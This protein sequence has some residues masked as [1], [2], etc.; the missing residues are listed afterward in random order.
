MMTDSIRLQ[1]PMAL[2]MMLTLGA[3]NGG[4]DS[5]EPPLAANGAASAVSGAGQ[6]ASAVGTALCTTAPSTVPTLGGL[7]HGAASATAGPAQTLTL[8]ETRIELQASALGVA[9]QW[10]QVSGPA[11]AVLQHANLPRTLVAADTPGDYVFKLTSTDCLGTVATSETRLK[12][13]PNPVVIT[14][15]STGLDH[16]LSLNRPVFKKGNTLLPLSQYSCGVGGSIRAELVKNWGYT[17]QFGSGIPVE[18]QLALVKA[19]PGQYP[20]EYNVGNVY[21]YFHNYRFGSDPLAP[22]LPDST[23][24]RDKNGNF[25]GGEVRQVSSAAPDASFFAVGAFIG[26]R[27]AAIE[28]A[29]GSKISLMVNGN[30][31]GLSGMPSDQDPVSMAHFAA[32]PFASDRFAYA[33]SQKARQEHFIKEGIFSR[34]KKGRPVYSLYGEAYGTERGRWWGWREYVST[35]E[36]WFTKDGTPLVSDYSAPEFYYTDFNSGWTGYH[37]GSMVP[38]DA[39]NNALKNVSGTLTVLKQK[40]F[41]PWISMGWDGHATSD[42][43]MFMGAMKAYYTAGALGASSGDYACKNNSPIYQDGPVGRNLP[44]QIKGFHALSHV[45]GLFTFLEDFVRN[46]DLLPSNDI[47]SFSEAGETPTP[48]MEFYAEN[49]IL[50][51]ELTDPMQP[52]GTIIMRGVRVL[53]RKSKSAD[54][55]MI[56]TWA[57]TGVDR[58]INVTVDPKL[59]AL[60][61]RARKSAAVYLVELKDGKPNVAL[62]DEDGMNPTRRFF[63]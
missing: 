5:A 21:G 8:P 15:Q 52:R 23:W 54:V 42:V 62:V 63:Q 40:Y 50:R 20:V 41:Y 38:Y 61:L 1:P 27:V 36:Q 18:Q 58:D 47:H 24:L 33:S 9:A 19:N 59:G 37:A 55:W 10:I 16:L 34:L 35:L 43:D 13:M 4:G 30:E 39:L 31:N 22:V 6:A 7:A 29:T 11:Q 53:A 56:T 49:E 48:A 17:A 2:A 32:S 60:T 45:H 26:D 28:E 14:D 25:L 51:K 46:S 44:T 57:N 3:C 12:V